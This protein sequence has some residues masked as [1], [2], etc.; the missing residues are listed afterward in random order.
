METEIQPGLIVE[1]VSRLICGEE[2]DGA[3]VPT[4]SVGRVVSQ[5]PGWAGTWAVE[6]GQGTAYRVGKELIK[7]LSPDS[8]KKIPTFTTTGVRFCEEIADA[9]TNAAQIE[10]TLGSSAVADVM[11]NDARTFRVF[12]ACSQEIDELDETEAARVIRALASVYGVGE[13]AR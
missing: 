1:N 8:G 2:F 5:D 12:Y 6:F 4:G 11:T 7:P 3:T 9:K 13:V 10:R